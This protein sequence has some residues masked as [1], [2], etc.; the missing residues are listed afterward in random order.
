M[1]VFLSRPDPEAGRKKPPPPL[2]SLGSQ[3]HTFRS[4]P[5]RAKLPGGFDGFDDDDRFVIVDH[6]VSIFVN[7]HWVA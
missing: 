1:A 6:W 5:A 2:G 3:S 4:S 7:F